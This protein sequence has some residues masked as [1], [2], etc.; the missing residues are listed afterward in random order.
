MFPWDLDH[1]MKVLCGM[2]TSDAS[3]QQGIILGSVGDA[4][5]IET[6]QGLFDSNKQP[7]RTTFEKYVVTETGNDLG[8]LYDFIASDS[9]RNAFS[10]CDERYSSVFEI[11]LKMIQKPNIFNLPAVGAEFMSAMLASFAHLISTILHLEGLVYGE[12]EEQRIRDFPTILPHQEFLIQHKH[13][14]DEKKATTFELHAFILYMASIELDFEEW[15]AEFELMSPS[16]FVPSCENGRIVYPMKT[17][18][19]WLRNDRGCRTW[20]QLAE[21]LQT[22]EQSVKNH[23][24]TKSLKKTPSWNEF[25]RMMNNA[26]VVDDRTTSF[27]VKISIAYGIARMMQEHTHRCLDHV[28]EH[29]CEPCEIGNYYLERIQDMRQNE[30]RRIPLHSSFTT[31]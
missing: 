14:S 22:S 15:D 16:Y 21:K 1:F 11:Q 18:W 19:T 8:I 24:N 29:F 10:D 7:R 4:P 27:M 30:C 23:A 12:V 6:L 3:R 25:W 2:G 17:F 20:K 26:Q 31:N 5:D 9:F 13:F 28:T